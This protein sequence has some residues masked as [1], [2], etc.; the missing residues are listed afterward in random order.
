MARMVILVLVSDLVSSSFFRREVCL[1][2]KARKSVAAVDGK[3]SVVLDMAGQH[4]MARDLRICALS[5]MEKTRTAKRDR[6]CLTINEGCHLMRS[7]KPAEAVEIFRAVLKQATSSRNRRLQKRSIQLS[8]PQLLHNL[9]SAL[10]MCGEFEE[11]VK[12]FRQELA[13]VGERFGAD[14]LE[15]GFTQLNL[16]M[17]L[18]NAGYLKQAKAA[19]YIGSSIFARAFGRE[20]EHVV[21]LHEFCFY[22]AGQKSNK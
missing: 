15:A 19:A 18:H 6:V 13:L 5:F 2:Q 14:S 11:A 17:A 1:D 3:L 8:L 21:S 4:E 9:G 22:L 12:I 16:S 10:S 20:D 7:G